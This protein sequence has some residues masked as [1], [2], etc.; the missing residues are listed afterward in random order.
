MMPKWNCVGVILIGVKFRIQVDVCARHH[1]RAGV[2]NR[3]KID[4]R[5]EL[6]EN[7]FLFN[8]TS[9]SPIFPSK[10]A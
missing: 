3:V 5:E 10:K 2:I 4:E 9:V 8:L 6:D 1:F 7:F